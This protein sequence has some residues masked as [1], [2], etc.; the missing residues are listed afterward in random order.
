MTTQI[1][2][3]VLVIG[4][5]LIGGSFAKA[6]KSS[7]PNNQIF[8]FDFDIDAIELAKK[9]GVIDGFCL[10]EDDL[11]E[12]DLIVIACPLASYSDIFKKLANSNLSQHAV[13]ID[14]GSLKSFIGKIL[15]SKIK[16]QFI[17]C[18]PIA[19]SD[20]TGFVNSSQ[21]LF[22]DKKFIICSENKNA[23]LL[24]LIAKIGGKTEFLDA[25]KH[26]GIYALV[27]HLPQFLSFLVKEFSPK[28]LTPEFF[29][30]AFRLDNSS[31]EIWQDI[32]KLNEKNLEKFYFEFFDNLEK[33]I[34][35][36]DGK[37]LDFWRNLEAQKIKNNQTISIDQKFIND[38]FASI[39][40]RYLVVLSYLQIAEIKNYQGF[41]GSG[42]QDFTSIAEI[43]KC[44]I[45]NFPDLIAKNK[46]K[47]NQFFNSLS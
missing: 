47:I 22:L 9:E 1:F 39:F 30:N 11:S 6:I 3:R 13:I 17:G 33:N 18:H 23:Q 46:N 36:F 15:P 8:A 4:L 40:F 44:D 32:F 26:D 42:F 38:N 19:G 14:L 37:N 35:S 31:P 43:V 24:N 29:K 45:A 5:G 21:N 41:A 12:F 2:K 7:F 25:K 34:N 28:N 20:K 27:S 16:T 10:L